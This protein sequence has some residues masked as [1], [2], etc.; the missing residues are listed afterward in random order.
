MKG[1]ILYVEKGEGRKEKGG[2]EEIRPPLGEKGGAL[3]PLF[4]CTGSG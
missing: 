4:L 2:E 3:R 1:G